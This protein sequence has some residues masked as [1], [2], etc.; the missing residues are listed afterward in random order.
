MY[1]LSVYF[2]EFYKHLYPH[3]HHHR[4]DTEHNHHTKN[5]PHASSRTIT[6]HSLLQV[7]I[8]LLIITIN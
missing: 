7:T 2:N 5:F 3:N 8:F 6:L 1:I 4:Q